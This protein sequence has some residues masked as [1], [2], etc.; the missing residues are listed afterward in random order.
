M[1]AVS[2]PE[3][4]EVETIRQSLL[5][6]LTG[7]RIDSVQVREK[8]LRYPVDAG[9]LERL[10]LGHT[11]QS[12]ERRSKYL[13]IRFDAQTA[14]V[15]HLGMS[16][17]ILLVKAGAEFARHDHVIFGLDNGVEMRFR[18][19]RRFGLVEAF[20]EAELDT[21]RHFKS[22]GLEPLSE[23]CTPEELFERSRKLKKPIKNFLMDAQVLV[24]VGNI[25]ASEA[26]FRARIRPTRPAGKLTLQDWK[27]L[28]R[29]VRSVLEKAIRE[30]GTTLRD[31]VDSDG[32]YG[33][34]QHSLFV[35]GR[36][37][38]ACRRCKTIIRRKI[39]AGRSTFYCPLCQR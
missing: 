2:M 13:V 27:H 18:D 38:K 1:L 3:L 7:R 33:G 10:V 25:Y 9:V 39:M 17:R 11:I 23:A 8:R 6:R 16:G 35:Y 28:H 19:H 14:L 5:P 26:L 12:I 4:P 34:Y 29:A 31:F 20:A 32:E 22:L 30:G 24:G 37:S 15:L 36:A 21:C